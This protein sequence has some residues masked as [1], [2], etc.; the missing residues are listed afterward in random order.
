MVR[1]AHA[2]YATAFKMIPVFFASWGPC[3]LV[4]L[5]IAYSDTLISMR[6]TQCVM[7]VNIF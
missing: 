3:P 7:Q 1:E 5:I 4:L 6:G 2:N